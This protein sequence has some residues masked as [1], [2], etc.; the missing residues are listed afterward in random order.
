MPSLSHAE[1]PS[2]ASVS[3]GAHSCRGLSKNRT[4]YACLGDLRARRVI[5][6]CFCPCLPSLPAA[7]G[8]TSHR[9]LKGG[10]SPA[11]LGWAFRTL[12]L[13]C[14][15]A[16]CL[17]DPP[18]CPGPPSPRPGRISFPG[19][20]RPNRAVPLVPRGAG[21][22]GSQRLHTTQPRSWLSCHRSGK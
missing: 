4:E 8:R 12:H 18:S 7:G 15:P 22:D 14:D 11:P 16:P 1:M 3:P 2:P 9:A 20:R 21:P 17:A 10:N 5:K 19:A 13:S 6:T